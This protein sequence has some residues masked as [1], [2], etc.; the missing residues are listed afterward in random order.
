[1]QMLLARGLLA[2]GTNGQAT[3]YDKPP[4]SGLSVSLKNMLIVRR[5]RLFIVGCLQLHI[6]HISGEGSVEKIIQ[7]NVKKR[8]VA[9]KPKCSVFMNF[10][11]KNLE[12]PGFPGRLRSKY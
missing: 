11:K 5:G 6:R 10:R 4:C 3:K 7:F 12:H 8:N 2:L 1:M 9:Y